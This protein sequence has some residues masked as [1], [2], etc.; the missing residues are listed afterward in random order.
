MQG[1]VQQHDSGR[2][3]PGPLHQQA[4]VGPSSD[5]NPDSLFDEFWEDQDYLSLPNGNIANA[6]GYQ[7]PRGRFRLRVE[8]SK[9][10]LTVILALLLLCGGAYAYAVYVME[11]DPLEE[12]T[13]L[14]SLGE[15]EAQEKSASP[16]SAPAIGDKDDP[17]DDRPSEMTSE[18]S[19]GLKPLPGNPY[20]ALPNSIVNGSKPR[21]IWTAEEEEKWR[22]GIVHKYPYQR[23]KA[24]QLARRERKRG[25]EAIFWDAIHDKKAW[26]RLFAIIGLAEFNVPI[27]NKTLLR[28]LG[29]SRSELISGFF[30]RFV[31]RPNPGQAYVMRQ[32]MRLL[33]EAG[34]LT[35]LRGIW[36]TRDPYRDLYLAAAT[37]D[38][39]SKVQTWVRNSLLN[40]PM[41][42]ERYEK[43]IAIAKG[44]MRSP[45]FEKLQKSQDAE[46]KDARQRGHQIAAD[47]LD[48][49]SLTGVSPEDPSATD[50][51][52]VEF[53]D[54]LSTKPKKKPQGQTAQDLE[55]KP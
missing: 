34:R 24:I 9:G 26:P 35:C 20:W 53:F 50:L 12:V 36:N 30:E 55:Y 39:G 40:K 19:S 54:A 45:T 51:G 29:N 5:Q 10:L 3:P 28:A 44:T 33:D 47:S 1:S 21:L 37:L 31:A 13:H 23:L 32:A 38:P 4:Q 25:A 41:S 42:L 46:M 2:Q 43:M 8:K 7:A 49:I 48:G 14:F 18:P 16:G 22:S 15:E 27:A 17:F 11:I 52:D 6:V